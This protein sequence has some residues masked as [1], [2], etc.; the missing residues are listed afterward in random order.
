M[1]KSSSQWVLMDDFWPQPLGFWTP[2]DVHGSRPQPDWP[3]GFPDGFVQKEL[4]QNVGIVMQK[5]MIKHDQTLDFLD[6]WGATSLERKRKW[7]TSSVVHNPIYKHQS[8]R[9]NWALLK[10][11]RLLY[12]VWG[13]D[14]SEILMDLTFQIH[15]GPS[16]IVQ[17]WKSRVFSGSTEISSAESVIH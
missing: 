17:L 2:P 3:P 13:E 8:P 14:C 9:M 15:T 12:F 5:M 1:E 6:F 16:Y 7:T 11:H 4:P 10:S